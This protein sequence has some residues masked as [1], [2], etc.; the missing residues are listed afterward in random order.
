[1]G[2]LCI[3]SGTDFKLVT[4]GRSI[5]LSAQEEHD[6]CPIERN[7]APKCQIVVR[8]LAP[9][10]RALRLVEV[11]GDVEPPADLEEVGEQDQ[12]EDRGA[13]KGDHV[14]P[15]RENLR[16]KNQRMEAIETKTDGHVGEGLELHEAWT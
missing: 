6:G 8:V 12:K 9:W 11:R 5:L 3:E 13:H 15:Q 4:T 2:V 16:M 10:N 14:V 7:H 1:M